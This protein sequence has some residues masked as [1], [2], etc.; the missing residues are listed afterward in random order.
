[1]GPTLPAGSLP[2]CAPLF[3]CS[4]IAGPGRV[5]GTCRGRPRDAL[6]SMSARL[7]FSAAS[8]LL[9]SHPKGASCPPVKVPR[10]GS[11]QHGKVEAVLASSHDHSELHLNDRAADLEKHLQTL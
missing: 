8:G 9:K 7:R 5:L 11:S 4:V 6:P 3:P 10:Q 2:T 1:M